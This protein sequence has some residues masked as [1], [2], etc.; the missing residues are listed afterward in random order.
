MRKSKI[1]DMRKKRGL[2]QAELAIMVGVAVNT[3]RSWEIN[4]IPIP[5]NAERLCKF[6]HCTL[7]ELGVYE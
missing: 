1:Y 4:T 2:T 3:I 5:D 6:L 7:E